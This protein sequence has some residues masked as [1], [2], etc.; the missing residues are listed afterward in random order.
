[1]KNVD[2][3]IFENVDKIKSHDTYQ[4]YSEIFNNLEEKPQMIAKIFMVFTI[5]FIPGLFLFIFSSL[6]GSIEASIEAKSEI[7]KTAEK[8]TSQKRQIINLSRTHLGNMISNKN[9]LETKLKSNLGSL[10]IEPT[11]IQITNFDSFE[12]DGLNKTSAEIKFKELSNLN[13]FSFLK[14]VSV[15]TKMR[16]EEIEIKKNKQSDLLEGFIKAL[17]FSKAIDE[18]AE[19]NE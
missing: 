6:N 1:M 19:A 9:M 4:E 18:D 11:K 16:I 17:H 8:I 2:D 3:F 5:F 14:L 10:N 15:R 13:L 12:E 7:L